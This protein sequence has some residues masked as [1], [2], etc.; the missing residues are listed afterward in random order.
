MM[1]GATA[2]MAAPGSW[3]AGGAVSGAHG[4]LGQAT[5]VLAVIVAAVALGASMRLERGRGPTLA[6]VADGLV[7]AVT[8]LVFVTLF[9]GGILLMTGLRPSSPV[10]ILLAVAALAALPVAGGAGLWAEHGAGRQPQRYRWLAGG[11]AVTALL[12]ILLALTG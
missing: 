8:V 3:E 4:I 6:R 12:G 10:H 9:I 11:A 1:P 5:V 2:A 7:I